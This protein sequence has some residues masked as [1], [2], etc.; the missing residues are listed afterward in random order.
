MEAISVLCATDNNYAPY[1]G[2][3]LTSLFE[4]NNDCRFEVFLLHDGCL[5]TANERKLE[6]LGSKYGNSIRLMAIDSTLVGGYSAHST[7]HI[8]TLPTFYRLIA[9]TVLPVELHKVIYLDCDVIVNG[10]VGAF[11]NIDMDGYALACVKDCLF[12]YNSQTYLRLGY[13]EEFGYFNAGILLINMDYWRIFDLPKLYKEFYRKAKPEQLWMMDQDILNSVLFDKKLFVSER[14][15]L[16]NLFFMRDN[17]KKYPTDFQEK[18][19]KESKEAVFLH[20]CGFLKPWNRMYNKAVFYQPWDY[21]RSVSLWSHCR[22]C[23][24]FNKY[25]KHLIKKVLFPS[26]LKGIWIQCFDE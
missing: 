4:S 3:M 12:N 2:I 23:K 19:M 15:N 5:S 11:W 8:M 6:L 21:Y 1:C 24:P 10:D 14:F 26:K 17:W 20:Y 22:T 25:V 9:T 7:S 18:L 16:Q 13:L